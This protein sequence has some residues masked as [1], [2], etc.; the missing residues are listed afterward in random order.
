MVDPTSDIGED[1]TEED[2]PRCETCGEPIVQEA[3][4]RVVTWVEGGETRTVHFCDEACRDE[5]DRSTQG[6]T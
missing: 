4:H 2:A 1:V 3:T 5:W 6:G